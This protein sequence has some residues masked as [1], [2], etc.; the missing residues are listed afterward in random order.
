MGSGVAWRLRRCGFDVLITEI[1]RPL[2]VRRWVAFSEA[3]YEG[4]HEIEGITARRAEPAG[5]DSV[6]RSGEIP[7][8]VCPSLDDLAQFHPDVIV[9]AILAKRNTGTVRG[10][11]RR[12]I[13]LGP[14]FSAGDDVD[15]VI[16]T[17]RGPNLGRCIWKG[18][19]EPNTGVPG[20]LAGESARRVL[21]APADGLVEPL[22][23]IGDLVKVGTPVARVAGI[24]VQSSLDGILRGVLREGTVITSGTKIGDVDPRGDRELCGRISEKALAI[25]GGVLEGILAQPAR[26]IT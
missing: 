1:A 21:R 24:E 2:A 12:V 22:Q 9:D 4:E 5:V 7:V 8:I 3:V 20:L 17:N 6:C 11:A 13:G 10:L 19:A 26:E 16:E 18:A 15:C 23:E 14:G 25:A